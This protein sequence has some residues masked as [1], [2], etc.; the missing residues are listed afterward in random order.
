MVELAKIRQQVQCCAV[1]RWLELHCDEASQFFP[2]LAIA[3]VCA[4]IAC[5][6]LV[7]QNFWLVNGA[8]LRKSPAQAS[9]SRPQP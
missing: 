7:G 9:L 4:D 5:Q 8:R 3:Q 1:I 6:Q 2:S